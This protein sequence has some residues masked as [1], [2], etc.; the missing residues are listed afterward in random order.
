MAVILIVSKCLAGV[1][2]RYDG[3]D[4][5]VPEIKAL[6]ERGEAVAVCT[7][8]L[9]GLPTPRTPCELQSDG[10]VLS[11]QG[12]DV[13]EAF[14]S[15]AERAMVLCR[16]HG[17]TDAILKARSPSC[18][19]GVVYNGSVNLP[20][21]ELRSAED[22]FPN[23]DTTLFVY[24]LSGARSSKAIAALGEMGCTKLT[25]LGGIRARRGGG[26]DR[27]GAAG[28]ELRTDA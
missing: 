6:V 25:N 26:R 13:T 15:G 12:E 14:V 7:E 20:L 16:E 8:A 28:F 5:L 19:K 17:C 21:S 2:C 3:K 23:T 27:D 24:C 1:P 11:K 18:G 22:R 10:R 4:N 9:G